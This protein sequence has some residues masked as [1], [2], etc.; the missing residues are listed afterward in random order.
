MVKGC[1]PNTQPPSWRT[2]HCR[3]SV[4]AYSVY[5]Q[6]PPFLH[7]L[8]EDAPCCGDRDPPN[9]GSKNAPSKI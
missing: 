1:W 3:F 4:A 2:T 6:L 7:P 9:I 5:S 8:P